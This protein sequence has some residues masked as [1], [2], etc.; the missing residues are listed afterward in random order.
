MGEQKANKKK[1]QA[2]ETWSSIQYL[3][4]I[5]HPF[6]ENTLEWRRI[7]ESWKAIRPFSFLTERER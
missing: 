4:I 7:I 6:F 2:H 5:I 1:K 3:I